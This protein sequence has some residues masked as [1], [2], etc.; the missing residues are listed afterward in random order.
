MFEKEAVEMTCPKCGHTSE[1]NVTRLK[2]NGYTCPKC[3]ATRDTSELA[4]G[5]KKVEDGVEKL[6]RGR[7]RAK[8]TAED[9]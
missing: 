6:K 9:G 8:K 7:A 3:G 4:R 5:F 2:A 1:E